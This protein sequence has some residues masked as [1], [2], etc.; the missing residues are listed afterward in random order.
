VTTGLPITTSLYLSTDP[1]DYG[2]KKTAGMTQ[3]EKDAAAAPQYIDA[4]T[5][6]FALQLCARGESAGITRQEKRGWLQTEALASQ[7]R[8]AS[9]L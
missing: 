5:S 8:C 3:T 9:S 1:S 6:K 7:F 4:L 2:Y